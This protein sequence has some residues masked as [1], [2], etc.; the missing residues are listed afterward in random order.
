MKKVVIMRGL[1]GS[2]KS[3][4][5]NNLIL[6]YGKGLGEHAIYCSTDDFFKDAE[7]IYSFNPALIGQAHNSCLRNYIQ[8]LRNKTNLVIVDNT[9]SQRWE[10][11]HYI[12]LAIMQGY[13]VE[14]YEFDCPTL[15]VAKAYFARQTHGVPLE[16][17]LGMWWRWEGHSAPMEQPA[18]Y[19]E[20]IGPLL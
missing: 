19:H 2:G 18:I 7:G 5:A 9:C 4:F 14:I 6:E 16:P 17:F 3:A 11:I 8:A 15:S 13:K 20:M 12:E 1:P 10:Y